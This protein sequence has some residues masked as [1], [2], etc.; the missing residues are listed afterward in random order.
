MI[1]QVAPT[2]TRDM[3]IPVNHV[4]SERKL[5]SGAKLVVVENAGLPL[6]SIA[7]WFPAGAR[8][9]PVDREGLAHFFEHLLMIKTRKYPSRKQRLEFIESNGL[10]FD[11][12]TSNETAHYYYIQPAGKL[13]LAL[14][15]LVDGL[16][17][18]IITNV[19]IKKEKAIVLDE[20]ARSRGDPAGY[21][22]RLTNKGLWPDH[23]LG[24]G[25]Y[26]NKQSITTISHRD[27]TTFL[28]KHYHPSDA[29]FVIVDNKNPDIQAEII[30]RSFIS[31]K[32]GQIVN[33]KREIMKPPL[34]LVV[35]KRNTDII[36]VSIG[37]RTCSLQAEDWITLRFLRSYLASGWISRLVQRLRV[38]KDYT[39]WVDG[40]ADNFRDT[41]LLRFQYSVAIDKL[42]RS[43][44]IIFDEIDRTKQRKIKRVDLQKHKN[45]FLTY[46]L[47]FNT[48][49]PY[50]V[51]WW[52]GWQATT[53][54]TIMTM[55]EYLEK[56]YSLNPTDIQKV[57][58]RYLNS[59]N[60]TIVL[61]GNVIK[62]QIK[63]E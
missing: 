19:D 5:R 50:D 60:R 48:L 58:V 21:A 25:F 63:I 10:Y 61:L 27:I 39:Y 49:D 18:S 20:E 32:R 55:N 56:I 17:H 29:T 9:D 11:A 14:E 44:R 23:R 12:F 51:Q 1:V 46:F 31:T 30:D 40:Y 16:N 47:K 35:E 57:A 26:G 36:S 3:K 59:E 28:Y 13:K 41:G 15:L 34:P 45:T 52:Y 42:Q 43:L 53:G 62:E 4:V 33:H 6:T 38:E 22:W 24:H 8:F 7:V 2:H 54:N 37:F